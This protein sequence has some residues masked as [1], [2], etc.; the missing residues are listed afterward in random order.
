MQRSS[1]NPTQVTAIVPA[2]DEETVIAECVASL[3]QQPEIAEI[4]VINDQSTDQTAAIVR[5]QMNSTPQLRLL[6][7]EALPP[8][9]VGK[10]YAVWLGAREAKSEWLLFTDA[11]ALHN[12]DS[13]ARAL[14]IAANENAAMVSFSP[15]QVMCTWYEKALIPY[16][17]CRLASKFSF[18]EINDPKSAA[19]A[20]N[21]QCLLIRKDVYEAVGGHASIAGEVLEDVALARRVKS[22]GYRLWF[23]SGQ[24]VV[25]VRMYRSFRAIWQGWKK[26]LFQLM[27]GNFQA[28]KN[29][30]ARAVLPTFITTVVAAAIGLFAGSVF[31]S[32]VVLI[33][34]ATSISFAYAWELRRNQFHSALAIYAIPASLLF[35][36]VLGASYLSHKRGK[37]E[38]KGREYPVGTPGASK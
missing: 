34:G 21:G 35:A 2:R 7:T 24:G 15:E 16:V 18:E 11:D 31:S 14:A 5:Q 26:N 27:G 19:A 25:R 32:L 30:I 6:Q 3:A 38:W 10:N 13:A 1:Q 29:E 8:G 20:A 4:L 9:W 28:I 36:A 23:G 17:Y 37:L 12:K 33:L 22:A